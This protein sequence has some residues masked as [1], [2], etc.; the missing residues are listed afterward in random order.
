ME[1]IEVALVLWGGIRLYL[2]SEHLPRGACITLPPL[3]FALFT[4]DVYKAGA[5]THYFTITSPYCTIYAPYFLIYIKASH[6]P[7]IIG[8][9]H[10]VINH[11]WN[12][13]DRK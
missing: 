5:P 3:I 4:T 12:G 2:L 7:S 6:C 9:H 11:V 13:Q 1:T 8:F 10:L